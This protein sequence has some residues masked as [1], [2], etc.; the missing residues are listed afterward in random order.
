MAR[1]LEAAGTAVGAGFGVVSRLRSARSLHPRGAVHSAQFTV[2]GRRDLPE[3]EGVTLLRTPAT[4]PAVVRFSRSLNLPELAPDILGMAIR[5]TDA[6]GPG[7]PQDLLLVTSGDGAVLHHLFAP[8]RGYFDRPYSSV[9]TFRGAAGPFVIGAR[10]APG[11]PRVRGRGSELADLGAAAATGRLA[12]DVGVAPLTGR[13]TPVATMVVGARLPEEAN[14]IR[15]NPAANTGGGLEL[16]GPVNRMRRWV[17]P[18]SQAGWA[19]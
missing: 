4:H 19:A 11:A 16:S 9:L 12:Y 13:M 5:L 15:F 1:A 2:H 3:L 17:Y 6:H 7:R 14:R 10:L 8:S 18:G